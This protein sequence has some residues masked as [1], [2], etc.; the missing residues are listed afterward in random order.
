[1]GTSRSAVLSHPRLHETCGVWYRVAL[2][3][4]L[5]LL[6]TLSFKKASIAEWNRYQTSLRY[7]HIEGSSKVRFAGQLVD[8]GVCTSFHMKL[9]KP[10]FPWIL[11]FLTM[12]FLKMFPAVHQDWY[13]PI[14][15]LTFRRC[16]LPQS[17]EKARSF[18]ELLVQTSTHPTGM[19]SE[20]NKDS[21]S[22]IVEHS[23]ASLNGGIEVIHPWVE[24]A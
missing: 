7:L 12:L 24:L 1:M 21:G 13:H 15:R 9:S 4:R 6:P 22:N 2:L 23:N 10:H 8:D 11:A 19:N 20:E 17:L 18:K 5:V 16:R 3:V 14:I